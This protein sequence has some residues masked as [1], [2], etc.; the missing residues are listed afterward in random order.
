[1]IN[2]N[3]R[4]YTESFIFFIFPPKIDFVLNSSYFVQ[5]TP[6]FIKRKINQAFYVPR[7]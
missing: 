5:Q 2:Y 7:M 3:K 4:L 1:M 6:H